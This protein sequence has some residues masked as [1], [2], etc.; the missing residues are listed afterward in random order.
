M[1]VVQEKEV[2]H[3]NKE[4]IV[5]GEKLLFMILQNLQFHNLCFLSHL[6]FRFNK[7]R[8]KGLWNFAILDFKDLRLKV[9]EEQS[10][11]LRGIVGLWIF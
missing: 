10:R 4:A 11:L 3:K 9:D 7:S 1:V 2:K 5:C 8:R 6:S